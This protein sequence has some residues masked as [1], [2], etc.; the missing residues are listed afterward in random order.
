MKK[1]KIRKVG[2]TKWLTIKMYI[3]GWWTKLKLKFYPPSRHKFSDGI[4]K[5]G[6][7]EIN[8]KHDDGTEDNIWVARW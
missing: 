8:I 5:D 1:V 7:D 4:V 3:E 2:F 6:V